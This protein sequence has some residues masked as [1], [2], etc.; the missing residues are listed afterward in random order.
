MNFVGG[1]ADQWWKLSRRFERALRSASNRL[2]PDG[3]RRLKLG[4]PVLIG[5]PAGDVMRMP[6]VLLGG[7]RELPVGYLVI[8]DT[9]IDN[10]RIDAMAKRFEDRARA[11]IDG[12]LGADV[13]VSESTYP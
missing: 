13:Q 10:G 3:G 6:V 4:S 7:E 2:D 1:Y 9:R 11:A 12:P 5:R 8:E